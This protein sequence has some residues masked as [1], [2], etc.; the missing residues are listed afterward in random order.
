MDSGQPELTEQQKQFRVK[1]EFM[2]RYMYDMGL[3]IPTVF[4]DN[5]DIQNAMLSQMLSTLVKIFHQTRIP[6]GIDITNQPSPHA[7]AVGQAIQTAMNKL[8]DE[9]EAIERI[10]VNSIPVG[11]RQLPYYKKHIDQLADEIEK[12]YAKPE[13]VSGVNGHLAIVK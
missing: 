9:L 8:F 12:I 6:A 1:L 11:I 3:I 7:G 4:A 13:L 10:V 5:R 2:F